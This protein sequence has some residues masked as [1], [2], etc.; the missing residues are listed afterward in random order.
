MP[1]QLRGF[2]VEG[3][4]Q[5]EGGSVLGSGSFG[6]VVKA[7]RI[8]DSEA[9]ALKIM[10][11]VAS[12]DGSRS[13]E[14]ARKERD[15]LTAIGDHPNIVQ[16]K[17]W[18]EL[19]PTDAEVALAGPLM[20]GIKAWMDA[21]STGRI[22]PK[23]MVR[24]GTNKI[25][26]A[27]LQTV[28]EEELYNHLG[29]H[30]AVQG[31]LS[32]PGPLGFAAE[33]VRP[34]T[35]QL[36]KAL[37]HVHS[38]GFGHFDLKLDNVRITVTPGQ[39]PKVWLVDFGLAVVPQAGRGPGYGEHPKKGTEGIV[40]PEFFIGETTAHVTAAA[41]IF[42]FGIALFTLAFGGPP[43]NM[44]SATR[45]R[46]YFGNYARLDRAIN[47]RG[48]PSLEPSSFEAYVAQNPS[49]K[50]QLSPTAPTLAPAAAA[51]APVVAACP[52]SVPAPSD[53]R[54]IDLL[55][56]MLQIDPAKRPTANGI[57]AHDWITNPVAPVPAEEPSFN[58][59]SASDDTEPQPMSCGATA[60]ATVSY[61]S[62]GDTELEPPKLTRGHALV[63]IEE[64]WAFTEFPV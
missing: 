58:N 17:G 59:C 51:P 7:T 48:A 53:P 33:F 35:Q 55:S 2:E 43:W 31:S 24:P 5:A 18:H 40:A 38:Q 42:S 25:C 32:P 27:A 34:V 22:T 49:F 60:P 64:G 12:G 6:L 21:E 52:T 44:A 20:R 9:V 36:A 3:N 39:D 56:K 46:G 37:Q 28:G 1:V 50:L 30:R 4:W 47:E 45:D 15:A 29:A 19:D 16:L 57:L 23:H 11:C 26:I 8:S 54:L 13:V 10:G 41:D 61:R 62:L 63:A 14:T